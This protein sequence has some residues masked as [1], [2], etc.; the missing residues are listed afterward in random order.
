MC[1]E[2]GIFGLARKVSTAHA[3]GLP[4]GVPTSEG[5]ETHEAVMTVQCPN[6]SKTGTCP[7]LHLRHQ[8]ITYPAPNCG[9]TEGLRSLET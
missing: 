8:G 7:T 4:S 2:I 1:G 9:A 6:K 3:E 5:R